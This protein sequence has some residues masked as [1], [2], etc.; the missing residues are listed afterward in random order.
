MLEDVHLELW[1]QQLLQLGE[2][3]GD[4]RVFVLPSLSHTRGGLLDT[5][6]QRLL[7]ALL[8]VVPAGTEGEVAAFKLN[9]MAYQQTVVDVL[10]VHRVETEHAIF[11]ERP[12][13]ASQAHAQ[14]GQAGVVMGRV[15]KASDQIL[16]VVHL[17]TRH[18][19]AAEPRLRAA[20]LGEVQ[21]RLADVQAGAVVAK[22][23]EM[24]HMGPGAAGQ[25]QVPTPVIAEQLVQPANAVTLC[26]IVDV[27]AHQVVV[28]GKIGVQRVGGHR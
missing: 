24:T 13:H 16:R 15:E 9:A 8:A 4:H 14:F 21:H 26:A 17:E 5:Q 3:E 2:T 7:L 1:R 27:G 19:L 23:E 22:V 6:A 25:V 11:G 28:D 20:Q 18:V 12:V 10:L